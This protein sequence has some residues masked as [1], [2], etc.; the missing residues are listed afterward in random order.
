MEEA[1][2]TSRKTEEK[3]IAKE[4]F[5]EDDDTEEASYEEF[6]DDGELIQDLEEEREAPP[7]QG[8]DTF[9]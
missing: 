1:H 8:G 3:A 9:F 5:V 4:E 7:A 2:K 6:E